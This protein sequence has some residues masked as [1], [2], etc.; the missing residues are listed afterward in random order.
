MIDDRWYLIYDIWYLMYVILYI[1]IDRSNL[2]AH[3]LKT[4][5]SSIAADLHDNAFLVRQ[6]S[7]AITAFTREAVPVML[8][9]GSWRTPSWVSFSP[10]ICDGTWGWLLGLVD[11]ASIY[12]QSKTENGVKKTLNISWRH[13][14]MSTKT[15]IEW[16]WVAFLVVSM[17]CHL[18]KKIILRAE[19]MVIIRQSFEADTVILF[20]SDWNPQAFAQDAPKKI[21]KIYAHF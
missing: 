8:H 5:K 3:H 6:R 10:V 13:E 2:H 1:N 19:E 14:E 18:S 4:R 15:L 21:R 9:L 20:D 7:I 12:K 16:Y 11:W 17:C